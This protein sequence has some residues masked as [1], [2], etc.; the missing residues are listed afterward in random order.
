MVRWHA[1]TEVSS[2][3]IQ[4]ERTSAWIHENFKIR[5]NPETLSRAWRH[6][7]EQGRVTTEEVK[8]KSPETCWGIKEIDGKSWANVRRSEAR[9]NT[10]EFPD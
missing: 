10:M 3:E 8:N 2:H 4:S 6:A 7:R 1:R 5:F 9:Q